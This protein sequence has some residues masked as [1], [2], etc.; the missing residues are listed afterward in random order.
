MQLTNET[1]AAAGQLGSCLGVSRRIR[2]VGS[3][4]D[5][6]R[7]GEAS[8]RMRSFNRSS[9]DNESEQQQREHA[10]K[11]VVLTDCL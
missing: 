8:V 2:K 9:V 6:L 4:S 5:S 1:V 10:P 7:G 11:R 3:A